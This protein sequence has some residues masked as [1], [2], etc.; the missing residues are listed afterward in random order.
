MNTKIWLSTFFLSLIAFVDIFDVL[1]TTN[2]HAQHNDDVSLNLKQDLFDDRFIE[3]DTNKSRNGS[4]GLPEKI[5]AKKIIKIMPAKATMSVTKKRNEN[6][7]CIDQS[8]YR[9]LAIKNIDKEFEALLYNRSFEKKVK[10]FKQG[11]PLEKG[12]FISKVNASHVYI[13]DNSSNKKWK[14]KMFDVNTTQY[15]PKGKD[16]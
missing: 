10:L 3:Y 15:K 14:F 8:C 6:M 9:L 12:I 7:I 11:S 16:D 4:W 13:E 1:E 2:K 5:I